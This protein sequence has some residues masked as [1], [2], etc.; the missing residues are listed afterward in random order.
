MTARPQRHSERCGLPWSA[1]SIGS[2]MRQGRSARELW[3][4]LPSFIEGPDIDQI[5]TVPGRSCKLDPLSKC[6]TKIRPILRVQATAAM[7][8]T[9]RP[10]RPLPG[11]M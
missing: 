5:F 4:L 7:D 11:T 1:D 6:S 2:T 9:A 8:D 10:M 3:K